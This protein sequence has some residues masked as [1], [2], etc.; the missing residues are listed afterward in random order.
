M[1][2]AA[3]CV[4][5]TKEDCVGCGVCMNLCPNQNI[6]MVSLGVTD[7]DAPVTPGSRWLV[8]NEREGIR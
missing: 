4:S 5:I 8:N 6:G 1:L 7:N 2:D 3:G